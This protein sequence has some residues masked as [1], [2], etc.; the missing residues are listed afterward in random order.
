MTEAQ[1]TLLRKLGVRDAALLVMGGIIGTGI[2]KTPSTVAKYMHT[3]PLIMTA[4]L[5][6]GLVALIGA[7]VFAELGAR[8]Q[9]TGGVYAYLRDAF[10]PIVAFGYG[11][12]LLTVS[13]AGGAAASAVT[14]ALYLPLVLG[15]TFND[16][17]TKVVGMIVIAIWTIVTCLGVRESTSTQNGF[18]IAKIIAIVSIAGIGLFAL[19]H[20]TVQAAVVPSN[21]NPIIALGLALVPV[22]FS[23]SGWQT[24]SFMS[25]EMK[26]PERNLPLGMLYG[27]LGVVVLYLAVTGVSVAVLGENGLALTKTPASDVVAAVFGSTGARIMAVVICVSTLGFI[28][29]QLISAPRVYYRMAEDG[30][31]F[32]ALAKIDART[33]VPVVAIGVQGAITI[34]LATGKFDQILNWVT[35]VDSFFFAFAALALIIFRRRDESSGKPQPFFKIPLHPWSTLVF[36][37]VEAAIVVDIAVNDPQNSWY[38]FLLLLSSVPVYY[39]FT[40]WHKRNNNAKAS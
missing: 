28:L 30:T 10:H 37:I 7:G 6:G 14:F 18:M 34:V 20:T 26:N 21:F 15:V 8:R 32:N 19:G 36:G 31:F 33:H 11:W 13:Q 2:F 29:N 3:T 38:G 23:Y 35:S 5:T 1:P 24:T 9:E 17:T 12:T 40:W 16:F 4:W 39:F 27:V 22:M 25:A